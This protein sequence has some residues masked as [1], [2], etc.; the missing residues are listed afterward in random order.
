MR[1]RAAMFAVEGPARRLPAQRAVRARTQRTDARRGRCR[2]GM[3]RRELAGA[4]ARDATAATRSR[5]A[6]RRY[7]RR[8]DAQPRG[9]HW[10]ARS[11]RSPSIR[12]WAGCRSRTRCRRDCPTSCDAASVECRGPQRR[13]ASPAALRPRGRRRR[14]AQ[15][16][17]SAAEPA[18]GQRP[19]HHPGPPS[20]HPVSGVERVDE[21]FHAGSR[22]GPRA[23]TRQHVRVNRRRH[24]PTSGNGSRNTPIAR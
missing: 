18:S 14:C 8:G 24:R 9:L 17:P 12:S 23:P 19:R 16:Q 10:R 15:P 20:R 13:S 3:D 1:C 11:T 6:S 21:E 5:D 22:R 7:R 2:A 4:A